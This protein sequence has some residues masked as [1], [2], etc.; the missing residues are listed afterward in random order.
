MKVKFYGTRGSTAI[1]RKDAV[2][3]G[4]NTTCLR[5]Y[6]DRLPAGTALFLDTGTGFVE[7]SKDLLKE[8][9]MKVFALFS[10]WHHDHTGG[11]LLAPHTHIPS[12]EFR[13]WGPAEHGQGPEEVISGLMCE[14]VFPVNFQK[15]RHRFKLNPLRHIGT[16]ILVVHPE[17]GFHLM[18]LHAFERTVKNGLK[19]ALGKGRYDISECLVVRMLKTMHPEYT[20]SYR[21]EEMSTVKVFVFLTDHE[22][23]DGIPGDLLRHVM[24]AHLLVQD[25]QYTREVYDAR[26]AGF[27][28]GTPDYCAK[29]AMRA[30]V[31]RLG[32]THH[33]PAASDE[34]VGKMVESAQMACFNH[35][36]KA[37]DVFGC[38][39]Y[40]EVEV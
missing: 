37:C 3:Y 38:A 8:G 17:A 32:L 24:S 31:K 10:H 35:G 9:I 6:S 39:D 5:L 13:I 28:H 2:G 7:A 29:L 16:Q 18:P 33:D 1:C 11:L 30:K 19:L 20:V 22:N 23:T 26:T 21:F 34:D 36:D 12:A 4:G 27:G 25:C 14:P 40:M 15:L